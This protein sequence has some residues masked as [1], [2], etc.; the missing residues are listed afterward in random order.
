LSKLHELALKNR[1]FPEFTVL[2]IY[3]LLFR[4]FEKPEIALKNR[5]AL[6]FFTVLNIR[7]T[8]RSF[9][10]LALALK[11]R[12]AQK[13]FAVWNIVFT[14]RSFEQLACAC[15]EKQTCPNILHCIEHVFFIIQEFRVTCA[16]TEK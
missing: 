7:Y 14:F 12:V 5:V 15:S 9:E 8:F 2:N 1:G 13:V 11:N 4:S 10:Q 6:E 16:C 3:F